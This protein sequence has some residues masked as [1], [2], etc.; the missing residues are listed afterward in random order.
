MSKTITITLPD[1]AYEALQTAAQRA[2]RSPEELVTDAVTAQYSTTENRLESSAQEDPVLA[3]MRSRGHLVD[4]HSLPPY[5][6]VAELPP[7]GSP[8]E[9]QLLEEIGNEASDALERM[10]IDIADLV[11]R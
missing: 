5:L 6:G 4:P 8:E 7:K 1:D 10:G 11:E 9:A 2:N 3:V